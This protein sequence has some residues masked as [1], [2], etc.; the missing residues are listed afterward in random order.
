MKTIVVTGCNG[1]IGSN[2]IEKLFKTKFYDEEFKIIG[3]DLPISCQREISKKF[4]DKLLYSYVN[5]EDLEH[6]L[7]A[8]KYLPDAIIHNGACS[9]TTET[10]PE[11]FKKLN[12]DY[13]KMLWNFCV[14]NSVPFIYAS[15]AAV[16]GDGSLGFSDKKED[17]YKYTSLN[18]Y[19]KSKLDFDQWVLEQT[20]TP[21]IWFGLRY[22]NVYGQY[23]SHKK[24]QA[25]MVYHGFFQAKDS[26]KIRLFQSNTKKYTDGNQ[27]RD[28]I[29]IDDIVEITMKLLKYSFEYKGSQT[30]L[31]NDGLFLN[32]GTGVART[33]NSLAE[34]VFSALKLKSNLEY[35]PIPNNIVHQ[36]QNFTC[37]DLSSLMNLSLNHSFFTLESGVKK[38]VTEYLVKG[39]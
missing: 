11:I 29:Y 20:K 25:S 13:S 2:V 18:L 4:S 15:S 38:Y 31:E 7:N 1:F 26:G 27:L 22:F 37:A 35:I 21:S 16:Y 39:L 19:G 10:D 14:K 12:V 32:L 24:G 28:F 36:Y 5:Y 23:E 6:K 3:S 9:S 17:C 8:L 30:K 33:W 34:S